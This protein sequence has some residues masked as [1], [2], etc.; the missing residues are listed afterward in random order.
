MKKLTI[1]ITKCTNPLT[2]S[3]KQP[4]N[5]HIAHCN[6]DKVQQTSKSFKDGAYSS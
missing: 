3:D 4:S 6:K 2:T 5:G 1:L